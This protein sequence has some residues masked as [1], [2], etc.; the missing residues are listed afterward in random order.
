MALPREVIETDHNLERV[1]DRASSQLA[2]HRWRWTL[3]VS[4]PGRISIGEYARQ[5]ARSESTIRSAVNGYAMWL[6]DHPSGGYPPKSLGDYQSRARM[7]SETEAAAQAVSKARGIAMETAR[8][9]HADEMRRVRDIA[10]QRAEERG[11]SIEEEAPKIAE[12]IA[13]HEKAQHAEQASQAEHTD[14]RFVE[15]EGYLIKAK[16]ELLRAL[17]LAPVVPWDDESRE[18]LSETVANVKA[19]IGLIDTALSGSSGIDWDAEF[20]KVAGREKL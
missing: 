5:V 10:R 4:N 17:K 16:R 14:I 8:R 12:T 13:R 20:A 2:Q 15:M 19:L 1:A 6:D 18:L 3:D 11:T 9:G 7:G